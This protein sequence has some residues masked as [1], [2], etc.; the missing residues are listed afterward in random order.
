LQMN[1]TKL[2][3]QRQRTLALSRQAQS[4]KE[5]IARMDSEI[6][7]TRRAQE[8]MN[9]A[10]ASPG[11]LLSMAALTPGGLRDLARLQPKMPF[12][13]ARGSLSLPV[14]GNLTKGF[15]ST[16]GFGG[17]ER[18]ITLSTRPDALVTMPMDGT[19][20]FA[21]PHRAYGQVLIINAGLGYH[22]TLAGMERLNVET[23]QFILAGEPIGVMGREAAGA[24]AETDGGKAVPALYIEF[25]KDG[26]PIDPNPWWAKSP[27]R[28][29]HEKARG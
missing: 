10:L 9:A 20:A 19:V 28:S 26:S 1:E 13:E 24:L 11:G 4:L 17:Q 18:G 8:A 12:Q 6:A 15:G 5:L 23:G 25:R 2:V 21:G 7:A 3:E 14:N 29:E 22:V 27:E 16:D